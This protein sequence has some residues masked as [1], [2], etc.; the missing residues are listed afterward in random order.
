MDTQKHGDHRRDSQVNAISNVI[1]NTTRDWTQVRA[2][3]KSKFGNVDIMLEP[4]M[5]MI[6]IKQLRK[7]DEDVDELFILT[8]DQTSLSNMLKL[9]GQS[10]EGLQ[11]C[12]AD[13]RH[14]QI[15]LTKEKIRKDVEEFVNCMIEKNKG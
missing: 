14:I 1:F 4:K 11:I 5:G 7:I 6:S 13:Y 15:R 8:K 10:I 9:L 2:F 3:S 12:T